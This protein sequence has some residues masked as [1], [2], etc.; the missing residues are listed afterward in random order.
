[1]TTC[2][3][4]LGPLKLFC[5][6]AAAAAAAAAPDAPVPAQGGC[7]VT[8]IV[9]AV[10]LLSPV[11]YLVLNTL[12]PTLLGS[13]DLKKKYGAEWAL[14][15]GSSSG[16]G[17]ELARRL[18]RQGLNV[19]LVARKEA[20]FDATVAELQGEFKDRSLLKVEADLS[21]ETGSW[22]AAVENAV[23]SKDVQVGSGG[24]A[25]PAAGS[26]SHSSRRLTTAA[27]HQTSSQHPPPPP[28][29]RSASSTP[30]I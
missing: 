15:T 28:M 2:A 5:E 16:I 8:M 7:V 30:A 22:M 27:L 20:V 24:P 4:Q 19:L 6:A 11:M 21:D 23:G 13:Q 29:R 26:S 14:V 1:M 10:L 17:K 18:L 3:L 25:C 9:L 12:V